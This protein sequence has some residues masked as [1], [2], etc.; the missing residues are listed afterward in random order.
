M[1]DTHAHLNFP[2]YRKDLR[3]VIERAVKSDVEKIICVSSNIADSQR[4][5]EI[6]QRFPEVYVAVGIHPHQTDPDNRMTIEKQIEILGRLA[7]QKKVVAIGECGLDFSPA[8]PGEK[9][10]KKEEQIFLFKHQI[11]L[12]RRLNLPI[13]IHSREAFGETIQILTE[14]LSQSQPKGVF[15]CYSAGKRKTKEVEKIGFYFGVDGN[16]TYDDG[17]QNVFAQIPITRIL[18][19]T[20]SPFLTPIPHRGQRNEPSFLPLVA[21]K[22]ADIKKLSLRKVDKITSQN[23][24]KLFRI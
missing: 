16:L 4:A 20:D 17:L 2:D 12:A 21:K 15:H 6:A 14:V 3:E 5:I 1:V 22:L 10:R 13:I 9:D 8:P 18:L 11:E 19:E 7:E 24:K 23:A